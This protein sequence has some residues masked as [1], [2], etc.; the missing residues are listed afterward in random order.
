MPMD[1]LKRR[2]AKDRDSYYFY[3]SVEMTSGLKNVGYYPRRCQRKPKLG[4][5][6]LPGRKWGK[7]WEVP[8]EGFVRRKVTDWGRV[9][10]A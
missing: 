3:P 5:A 8:V 1:R 10:R 6:R 2:G 9:K 4:K 7:G